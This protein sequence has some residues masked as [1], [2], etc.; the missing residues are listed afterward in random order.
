M[1]HPL[2]AFKAEAD[3]SLAHETVDDNWPGGLA[4]KV[5][6][7]LKEIDQLKDSVTEVELC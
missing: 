1:A 6:K 3:I 7:A 5:V 2:S 4:Y